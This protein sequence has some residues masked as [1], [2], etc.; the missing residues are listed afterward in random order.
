MDVHQGRLTQ[1]FRGA[2]KRAG[3]EEFEVTDWYL[4]KKKLAAGRLSP[5]TELL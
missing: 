2:E 3:S 4:S 5:E 1:L